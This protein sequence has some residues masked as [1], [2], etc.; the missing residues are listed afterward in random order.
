MSK[1]I[2]L[3]FLL[4]FSSV[5]LFKDDSAVFKLTAKN[6]QST[7]LDSDEFWLVEFYGKDVSMQLL[8]AATAS[9]LPHNF[10]RQQRS[11]T[12]LFEWAL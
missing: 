1:R 2:L 3:L 8:G 10:R 11:W 9:D 6:F 7:V 5:C 12:A 4:I